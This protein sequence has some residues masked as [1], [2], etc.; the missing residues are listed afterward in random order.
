MPRTHEPSIIILSLN[1]NVPYSID[2]TV[3]AYW[4][5]TIRQIRLTYAPMVITSTTGKGTSKTSSFSRFSIANYIL[6]TYGCREA[7]CFTSFDLSIWVWLKKF[8]LF[9][10]F[11]LTEPEVHRYKY[12]DNIDHVQK[13]IIRMTYCSHKLLVIEGANDNLHHVS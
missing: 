6:H 7:V 4:I 3:V 5:G 1:G 10:S 11:S 9:Y 8:K 12:C 2:A 13:D